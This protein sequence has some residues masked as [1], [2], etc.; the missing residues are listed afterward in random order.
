[1]NRI[2]SAFQQAVFAFIADGEGNAMVDAVAGSGKTTTI[3][4]AL[5]YIPTSK[6]VLFCAFNK[7]TAVELGERVK[8]SGYSNVN[9][10]TLHSL[11]LRSVTAALG[12][13]AVD[14]DKA[15]KA[16]RENIST[17]SGSSLSTSGRARSPRRFRSRR[18]T[19]P[20]RPKRSTTSSTS[21]SSCRRR[22]S[23]SGRRSSAPSRRCSRRPKRTRRSSTSMTWSGCRR[24]ST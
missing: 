4:E 11:G 8:A 5:K 14:G 1:M 15:D 13:P 23:R 2:W 22:R 12:R 20:T 19:S 9:V 3:L 7:T 10:S 21:T 16:A 24:R 17:P 6:R 18:A